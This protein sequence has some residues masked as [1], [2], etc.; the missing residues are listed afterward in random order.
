MASSRGTKVTTDPETFNDPKYENPGTVTSDSLAAESIRDGESFAADSDSRGPNSQ[1]SYST[2]TNT[3]DTSSATVLDAAPDAEARLANENWSEQSQ[4]NAGQGLGKEAGV[5]PTFNTT[6]SGGDSG[7]S[8]AY[9]GSGQGAPAPSAFSTNTSG[10]GQDEQP[11]GKNLREGGF[12]DSAPNAS[13][14]ADIGGKNDP[15]RVALGKF[16]ES[17]VPVAGGAGPRQTA[18]DGDNPYDELNRNA[19]S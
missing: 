3:T 11:H 14:N 19:S 6:S 16:E 4:L 7:S 15:G 8:D 17:D 1:P 18:I 10:Y 2:T 5:G 9:P 13:Y 12:D